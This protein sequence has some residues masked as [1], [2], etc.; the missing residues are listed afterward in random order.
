LGTGSNLRETTPGACSSDVT[1]FDTHPHLSRRSQAKEEKKE[2][3][4]A[5]KRSR[6]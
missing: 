3:E 4:E 1:Q 5:S 2:K 6:S